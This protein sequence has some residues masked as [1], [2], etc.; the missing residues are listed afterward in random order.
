MTAGITD[1]RA[2]YFAATSLVGRPW[3]SQPVEHPWV[4]E[5][6]WFRAREFEVTVGSVGFVGYYAG[7]DLYVVDHHALTD[8]F[9]ARIPRDVTVPWRPGHYER[10]MPAGYLETLRTG[11]VRLVEPEHRALWEE[12]EWR[13]RDPVFDRDRMARLVGL[14]P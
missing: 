1:E 2:Y 10:A 9:L 14:A 7:P 8:A 5:I 4:D 6:G 11:Q 13:T 12:I 3:R